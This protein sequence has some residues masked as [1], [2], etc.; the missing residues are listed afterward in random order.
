[1]LLVHG[2][3]ESSYMWRAA[4]P[5][6][7]AAGYRAIAPDLAGY[8]DSE[9]NPP[10]T[11]E[12]H[13]ECFEEFRL[14]LGIER[15][16]LVMHDWG[17]PIGL[18]WACEHPEAISALVVSDGG[19]FSDRRWH[20]MANVMRTPGDGEALLDGFTP[21]GLAYALRELCPPLSD[22]AVSEYWK[23]FNDPDRRQGSLELYRSGD[24]EKFAP[25]ERQPG[26]LGVPALVLWGANDRFAGVPMAQRFHEE[27]PG[28]ELVILQDAGHFIWDE[29]PE[30]TAQITADFLARVRA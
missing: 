8:G 19:F 18:R 23:A 15:A 14:A 7:A 17:V 6:I 30:Q 1:V 28:S 16:A 13:V 4:L 2:W 29:Q 10:G 27:L 22:E 20:D 21:E 12:H 26:T 5:A 9:P 11:W 3:P 24:F 25:Y